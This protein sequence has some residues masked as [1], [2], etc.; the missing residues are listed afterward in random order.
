MH[1]SFL[2]VGDPIAKRLI[3]TTDGT[4]RTV[5]RAYLPVSHNLDPFSPARDNAA[6]QVGLRERTRSPGCLARL[7]TLQRR[8]SACALPHVCVDMVDYTW[9]LSLRNVT[10]SSNL[11]HRGQK[12]NFCR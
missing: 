11:T 1:I 8:R 9:L 7:D 2:T 6:N 3:R 4:A 12:D 5:Y 10:R